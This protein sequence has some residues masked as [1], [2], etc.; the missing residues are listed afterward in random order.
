MPEEVIR[1]QGRERFQVSVFR[2]QGG[3]RFQVSVF[4]F[5]EVKAES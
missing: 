1:F 5:R 2:F 3:K 4:K